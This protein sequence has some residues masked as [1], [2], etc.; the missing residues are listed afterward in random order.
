MPLNEIAVGD[1]FLIRPGDVMPVDGVVIEGETTVD[2]SALTGAAAPVAK[3]KGSTVYAATANQG[4]A[5]ICRATRI[6]PD[7]TAAQLVHTVQTTAAA[8][9]PLSSLADKVRSVFVPA[10][11]GIACVVLIIWL[12][13]GQSFAFALARAIS[14]LAVSSPCVLALA[15]SAAI[16]SGASVGAKHGI[17]FKTAASLQSIGTLHIAVLD[18]AGT[19]TNGEPEVVT[20]VG[21]RSVPAKFLLGMA[22]GLESQSQDPLARAVM[23][24]AA[25][26]NIKLSTVKDVTILDGQGL[27][28]KVAGKVMAGGSAEFIAAQC[29]LTP[30]LQQAGEQLAADGIAPLYFSLDGHAAGLI[31]VADAVKPAS[32]AALDALKALGLDVILLTG[33]SRTNADRVAAQV[34]LDDAHVVSGL[35]PAELEAEL[36]R[37]QTNG[38]AAMIGSTSAAAALACADI[39][40]GMGAEPLPA[41]DVML[42]RDD[43]ADAAAA[44]RISRAV[45]ARIAQNTRMALVYSALLP[46]L[47]AGVLYPLNFVLHPIDSV[48]L[49]TLFVAWLLSGTARLNSF[50]PKPASQS[51]PQK[52]PAE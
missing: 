17:V 19:I 51:E 2:E 16:M 15:A 43:L 29:E 14:V 11:I 13:L 42:L 20:I 21:T 32:K 4:G 49:M 31:G 40:I 52:E 5:L 10:V 37:L 35:A 6:G 30:D 8:K 12:L 3:H 45:D 47:A 27:T 25:A 41:A 24:K 18:K 9:V 48:I 23:R 38:P 36:R 28:G 39:G 7:S 33:D 50:D 1:I 46:L 44:V 22:A 26:E 34:G